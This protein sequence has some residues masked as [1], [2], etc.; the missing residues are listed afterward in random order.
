MT[1]SGG[2]LGKKNGKL[3]YTVEFIRDSVA[4]YARSALPF[5]SD[6]HT[7]VQDV[8]ASASTPPSEAS[9]ANAIRDLQA[10]DDLYEVMTLNHVARR[11]SKT[12]G[13][14]L[15]SLYSKGFTRPAVVRATEDAD[16]NDRDA[17]MGFLVDKLKLAVRRE[18]TFGHLPICWGVLTAALGLSLGARP[19]F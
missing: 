13:V 14:A 11:A 7:L 10:L 19:P 5:V 12:Q 16:E 6:A 15:L 3:E 4:S 9:M 17:Q 2:D 8:L 1:P 18:E